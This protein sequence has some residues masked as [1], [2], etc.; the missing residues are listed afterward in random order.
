MQTLLVQFS[1]L[2]R[3]LHAQ[4]I[5]ATSL[6]GE[7]QTN[8]SL[9]SRRSYKRAPNHF[10]QIS[11]HVDMHPVSCNNVAR[12]TLSAWYRLNLK[13]D[14]NLNLSKTKWWCTLQ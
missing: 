12:G 13:S 8:I 3:A 2:A 7:A 10:R 6:G 11:P 1:I 14:N 5:K 9:K 4:T